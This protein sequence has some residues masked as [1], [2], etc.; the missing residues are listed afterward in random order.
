M[1]TEPYDRTLEHSL[2][3]TRRSE[4]LWMGLMTVLEWAK[5]MGENRSNV[6]GA[7]A[8]QRDTTNVYLVT[9]R[10]GVHIDDRW[11]YAQQ[12]LILKGQFQSDWNSGFVLPADNIV[13]QA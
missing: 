4:D 3:L 12:P 9:S 11:V 2:T 7:P 8:F 6:S 10:D 1:R 5:D 13:Q